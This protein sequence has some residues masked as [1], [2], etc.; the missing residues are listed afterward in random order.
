MDYIQKNLDTKNGLKKVAIVT[1][2]AKGIGASIVKTLANDGYFVVVNYNS[3][4]SEA[5]ELTKNTPNTIAIQCD[6][7][8]ADEVKNFYNKLIDYKISQPYIL[9]NNAGIAQQ[10]LFT[11]ITEQDFDDMYNVN[12]KGTFNMCKQ[13]IPSMINKKEGKIVN[14]SSIWGIEGASCEVHYSAMKAGLIGFTK[15]LAKEVG[16]SNINVNCVAP[17]VIMTDMCSHFSDEILNELKEETSLMRLGTPQDI[18]N[19]VS[20]LVSDNSSFITGDVITPRG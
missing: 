15:A 16:P 8:K 2:G 11:D 19:V 18:A 3:S 1:G 10:K 14:I 6:I 9:I 13:F 17:G 12:L 5:L 7:T 20:F 4:E